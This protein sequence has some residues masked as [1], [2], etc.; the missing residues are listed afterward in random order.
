MESKLSKSKTCNVLRVR[1]WMESWQK[2]Q[3]LRRQRPRH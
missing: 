3:R 1:I 2:R